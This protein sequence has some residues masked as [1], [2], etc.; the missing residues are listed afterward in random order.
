MYSDRCYYL[1]RC[2]FGICKAWENFTA[3]RDYKFVDSTIT[4]LSGA[5]NAH[6]LQERKKSRLV[7][8]NSRPEFN[9]SWNPSQGHPKNRES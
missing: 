9:L 2:P 4:D 7:K 1:Q 6:S 3:K 5:K 8:A